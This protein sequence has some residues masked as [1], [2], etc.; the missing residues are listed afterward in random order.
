VSI[1]ST[2]GGGRRV[3]DFTVAG[4][5]DFFVRAGAADVLV[6][7]CGDL[8]L[9]EGTAG[10]HTLGD[11]VNTTP[12][13]AIQKAIAETAKQGKTVPTGVWAD[14]ATAQRAVNQAIMNY[15]KKYPR[16]LA[17]WFA[18]VGKGG[19]DQLPLK[20]SFTSGTS[21]GKIYYPDGT[22]RDAGNT[23]TVILKR[24]KGHNQG[25]VVFTAYPNP[26]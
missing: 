6:H 1:S 20:G 7:N 16:G 23:F 19:S 12:E 14:Q 3:L 17:D 8:A 11:H 24:A 25:F 10:A 5:H 22:V 26:A 15:V 18:R 4:T 21:L 13:K 2:P 9:D